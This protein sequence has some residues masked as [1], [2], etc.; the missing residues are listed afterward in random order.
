MAHILNAKGL[1]YLDTYWGVA[2]NRVS[3]DMCG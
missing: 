3:R 2:Q 1:G